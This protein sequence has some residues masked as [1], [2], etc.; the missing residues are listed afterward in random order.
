MGEA[1]RRSRVVIADATYQ[2]APDVIEGL[3]ERFAI[4]WEGK[5]VL[6][7]PNMLAAWQP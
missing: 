6:L 2:T 4:D 7:K 5:R 1:S 3:I